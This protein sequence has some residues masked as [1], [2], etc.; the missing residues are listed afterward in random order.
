MS[1]IYRSVMCQVHSTDCGLEF[2]L[3]TMGLPERVQYLRKVFEV[4][5]KGPWTR[6][7]S[8]DVTSDTAD[9]RVKKYAALVFEAIDDVHL[10]RL[11]NI[12]QS[13]NREPESWY[14][15][16]EDEEGKAAWNRASDQACLEIA[17]MALEMY[18]AL[19]ENLVKPCLVRTRQY[20]IER[21]V[22]YWSHGESGE[23]ATQCF[24]FL[25]AIYSSSS[26]RAYY[27]LITE[28]VRENNR[29]PIRAG[30]YEAAMK[31]VKPDES[32]EP[33]IRVLALSLTRDLSVPDLQARLT[34]QV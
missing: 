31:L 33:L 7:P 23:K 11:A 12:E 30:R 24:N 34:R 19:P 29:R 14:E 25:L 8:G 17:S 6:A 21:L 1:C 3:K 16:P 22:Y 9:E 20:L 28:A 4:A 32:H 18:P 26:H 13:K 27:Q 10:L 2:A 15:I 5:L